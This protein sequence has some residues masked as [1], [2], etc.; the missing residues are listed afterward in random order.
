MTRRRSLTRPETLVPWLDL[1]SPRDPGHQHRVS[2]TI[3]TEAVYNLVNALT[4][5]GHRCGRTLY[6]HPP[7][8]DAPEEER[9]LK[10]QRKFDASIRLI[11]ASRPVLDEDAS[12]NPRVRKP[13]YT[14]LEQPFHES[15]RPAF[16]II[17][18]NILV[19]AP[20]LRRLLPPG[21][22]SRGHIEFSQRQGSRY[23]K[24]A[25]R[26]PKEPRTAV[27]VLSKPDFYQ[28]ASLTSIVGMCGLSVLIWSQLLSERHVEWLTRPGLRMVELI[29]TRIPPRAEDLGY[30]DEWQA[31]SL[32]HV[33]P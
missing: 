4:P 21:F 31:V 3:D 7:K 10:F 27:F 22:E 26:L 11:R 13:A 30:T 18:R 20:H 15:W 17:R 32:F 9:W 5:L 28:G 6:N 12:A 16:A 24:L 25:G 14:E 23:T 1:D 29:G 19:L 8:A 33:E 2:R